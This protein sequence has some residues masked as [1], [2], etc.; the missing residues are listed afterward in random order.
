MRPDGVAVISPKGN[1]AAGI[2]EGIEDFLV[3]QF[4]AKVAVEGSDEGVLL[5]LSGIDVSPVMSFCS[6]HFRMARLVNSVPLLG[7]TTP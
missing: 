4:I 6:A 3:K 1:L 5:R 2:L 7:T